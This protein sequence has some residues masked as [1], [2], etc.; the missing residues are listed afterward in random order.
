MT[1]PDGMGFMLNGLNYRCVGP[2]WSS[3]NL[4]QCYHVMVAPEDTICL[5]SKRHLF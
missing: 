2:R 4:L 5:I 3:E 1:T